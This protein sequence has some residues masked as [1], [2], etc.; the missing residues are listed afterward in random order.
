MRSPLSQNAR[1]DFQTTWKIWKAKLTHSENSVYISLAGSVRS[2][3]TRRLLLTGSGPAC[4]KNT[5]LCPSMTN[6]TASRLFGRSRPDIFIGNVLR[7]MPP[8]PGLAGAD[9]QC[10]GGLGAIFGESAAA[11]SQ[12]HNRSSEQPRLRLCYHHCFVARCSGSVLCQAEG[13]GGVRYAC[14]SRGVTWGA[15]FVLR[16]L[17]ELAA[18]TPLAV[19]QSPAPAPRQPS[20]PPADQR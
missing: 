16:R 1:N 19:P 20:S 11:R 5:C 14:P 18:C 6:S 7:S 9:L 13:G 17:T 2:Y 3:T 8:W 4:A 15:F 10:A 12:G